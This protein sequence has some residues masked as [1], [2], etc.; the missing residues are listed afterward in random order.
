MTKN[1]LLLTDSYK[2]SHW[3]MYPPRTETIYSYFESRGGKY[4][5]VV[6]CGLQGILQQHFA[7]VRVTSKAIEEAEVVLDAHFGRRV[8]HKAGWEH[9]IAAHRGL[10]PLSVK[11]VPEG[12][13][14]PV[15][16]V[17]M[18][19]ENTCPECYWLTNYAETVA[20]ET[21]F[22]CTVATISRQAKKIILRYL[23]RTGDPSL[24]DFKLHDFGFRGVSS[25]ESAAIGGCAHLINFQGTDTL[26]ALQYARDYYHEPMAGYSI[27][28]TEH[29][30]MT[31]N[32]P[33]GELDMMRRML[34]TYPEG[35]VAMVIDSYDPWDAIST[36]IGGVLR[37]EIL[38]R[39]GT[40]VV[41]PDSG[42]PPKVVREVHERLWEKFGGLTNQKGYKVLDPHVRVIQGD[43][44]NLD[45]IE[46]C[47]HQLQE[48]GFSADNVAFG[49]GGALLQ[50]CNRDTQR[51]AFKCSSRTIDGVEAAVY[52]QPLLDTQKDSKRGRLALVPGVK[53]LTTVTQASLNARGGKWPE[54]DQLV[55][56]FRNGAV[57][58]DWTLQQVR[59]RAALTETPLALTV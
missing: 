49:M 10:L 38:A 30:V 25:P 7:G 32:G 16:N 18:T 43:G 59:D 46:E 24:I 58:K 52:K 17:L 41:R 3:A 11:A 44:V 28:A 45:S 57:I 31:I 20:V 33:D 26:V 5:E 51:F 50:Q 1:F 2:Q 35:L 53:G 55:E 12:T 48:A 47:L 42:Y 8:F 29:S 19:I 40:V 15:S 36:K 21:W 4:P 37:A 34:A 9:I 23:E 54:T 22:P 56:V 39:K 14:V 6:F 27:P 13:V